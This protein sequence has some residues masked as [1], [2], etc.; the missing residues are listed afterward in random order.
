[1]DT[2][3]VGLE[4]PI[5]GKTKAR[6]RLLYGHAVCKR[7]YYAFA[8]RRQFAFAIDAIVWYCFLLL[9]QSIGLSY[10]P[11]AN[12]YFLLS[13]NF[14]F[15]DGFL[16]YSLGKAMMGVQVI[17]TSTGRPC[18]FV[19][20][21]QRNLPLMIPLVPLYVSSQLC[22]GQRIGDGWSSTG[23]IWKKHADKVPFVLE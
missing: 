2:Q 19:A 13:L 9:L 16:G 5:C 14:L 1:M 10:Y 7:C 21:F 15:K 12:L 20:S 3:D 4:C 23:V 18:D 17:D 11:N 22:Q 8:N 6:K